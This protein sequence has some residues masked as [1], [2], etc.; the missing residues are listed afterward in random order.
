MN[1]LRPKNKICFQNK[2]LRANLRFFKYRNKKWNILRKQIKYRKE[3]KP[4][5]RKRF[6]QKRLFEKQQFQNFYQVK[7]YQLKNKLEMKMTTQYD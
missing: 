4:E 6:F 2:A 1:K 3:L 7:Y 5:S